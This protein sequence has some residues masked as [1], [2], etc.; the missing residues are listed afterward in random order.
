[1]L[2]IERAV[3]GCD[4]GGTSWTTRGEAGRVAELLEL[5]PGKRL[6]DVGGGA[7]WPGLYLARTSGC[8]VTL[9]D[10]PEEG[11]R[12][13]A[14]RA[15]AD[16]L[17]GDCWVAVADGGALPF[18][19]G[20]FDAISHSDVLCCLEAKRTVLNACRQV[21]RR[22]GRVV[23]TVVT[24]APDLSPSQHDQAV[25]FGP[26][27]VDPEATFFDASATKGDLGPDQPGS[28]ADWPVGP[29]D[30]PA[31]DYRRFAPEPPSNK[32]AYFL[33]DPERELE[34][35]AAVNTE[36]RVLIAYL[37]HR[38]D[39]PW[40]MVWE[41]NRELQVPPWNGKAMTRGMEF[42]NTR[43]PG[44]ASEYFKHPE[45]Y[46]TRTFGWFEGKEKITARYLAFMASVPEEFSGVKDIAIEGGE[47]VVQGV[48]VE[49]PV[50][51]AFTPDLF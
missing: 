40:M 32:M 49:A 37:F 27:F 1:M 28:L 15:G 18:K 4:Y 12:I 46:G 50:R 43:I 36:Q 8:D 7:G 30:A 22:E 24:I 20:S 5:G 3:C 51:V 38:K 26:P 47:I 25:E 39:Y 29:A 17:P 33:M 6:L 11:M 14:G 13:A 35:I 31:M 41:E 48:G 42:G 34:Y 45:M 9:V 2:D 23:F 10:I 21:I 44:T 16:E 19:A